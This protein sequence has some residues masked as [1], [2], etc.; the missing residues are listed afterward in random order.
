MLRTIVTKFLSDGGVSDEW[1]ETFTSPYSLARF[2]IALTHESANPDPTKNYEYHEF[3]GDTIVNLCVLNWVKTSHPEITSVKWLAEIKSV[4]QSTSVISQIGREI[5]I[6]NYVRYTATTT[7]PPP[8][9]V[10]IEDCVEA[11]CGCF[12]E[13]V[14][15][16]GLDMAVG[17]GVC[18]RIIHTHLDMINPPITNFKWVWTPIQRLKEMYDSLK[19][20]HGWIEYRNGSNIRIVLK[21]WSTFDVNN[22]H[23]DVRETLTCG[24]QSQGL[25]LRAKL[26]NTATR[27][28]HNEINSKSLID[29]INT[30]IRGAQS[31]F[32]Y[33]EQFRTI[34]PDRIIND[35][36]RK[37]FTVWF[38]IGKDVA[39]SCGNLDTYQ[40]LKQPTA[41]EAITQI[42]RLL[43]TLQPKIPDIKAVPKQQHPTPT[44]SSSSSDNK[45]FKNNN[46]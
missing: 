39:S 44:P 18:N 17:I 25:P 4:L 36:Q 31:R 43:P 9:D 12:M 28:S 42:S 1:L 16:N 46:R 14:M 33:D 22:A 26:V 29:F 21:E 20:P 5:G 34:L 3:F 13:L 32:S 27:L 10:I 37:Q 41:E 23:P 6:Q 11:M 38:G 24:L 40:S 15:E 8:L 19:W 35:V 45:N 7:P 30:S 2:E